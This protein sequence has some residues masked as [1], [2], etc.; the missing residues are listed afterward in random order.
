M[1]QKPKSKPF[2]SKAEFVKTRRSEISRDFMLH[3]D[4]WPKTSS[5]SQRIFLK[6]IEGQN[7]DMGQLAYLEGRWGF[8]TETIPFAPDVPI[9][10]GG[11][12]LIDEIILAG[13][14]VD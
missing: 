7:P 4:R 2:A 5:W 14:V 1:S 3:P 6:R 10:W 12:E 13:W 8:V 9:K 11:P